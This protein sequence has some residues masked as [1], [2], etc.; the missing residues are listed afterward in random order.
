MNI[1]DFLKSKDTILLDGA[2]GSQLIEQGL[3]AG[4]AAE[5]WNVE[6]PERVMAVHRNYIEAGSQ[7]V[8][9]NSFGGNRFRLSEHGLGD[10][11]HE[12]NKAAAEILCKAIDESGKEAFAAGSMGPTGGFL[13][14]LGALS[15]GEVKEV[16]AIQAEALAQGGVDLFWIETFSA[17][18][19]IIAA[20]E[21]V[22]SG[23]QL[24]IVVTMTFDTKGRTMMGVSPEQMV[25]DL[26]SYG[27]LALGANCGNG[28]AEI[29]EVVQR[30]HAF[31]PALPIVAKSNAGIPRVVAGETV[32]DGTPLVMAGYAKEAQES[33][34]SLIGA[35]CG[36][37]PEYISA[38]CGVLF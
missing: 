15:Y 2:M 24:P 23:S 8:L 3:E 27:L 37:G 33:G 19:E 1:Q 35:C 20:I 29:I 28:P 11:V 10:R 22:Q 18:D 12:L 5:A 34:A 9:S 13:E 36:S 14:P 4:E 26:K 30:M 32:Y 25:E 6:H 21:G 16:Y 38:M 7:I 17:I 31:D